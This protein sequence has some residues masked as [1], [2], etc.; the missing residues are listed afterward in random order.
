MKTKLSIL[1]AIAAFPLIAA[2]PSNAIPG[3]GTQMPAGEG[4]QVPNATYTGAIVGGGTVDFDVSPDGTRVT[5]F[6]AA[7]VP[8]RHVLGTCTSTWVATGSILIINNAFEA[9]GIETITTFEFSGMFPAPQQARGTVEVNDLGCHTDTLPWTAS[10]TTSMPAPQSITFPALSDTRLSAGPITLAASASSGLPVSYTSSTPAVC[11]IA[12]TQATLAAVGSCSITAR[13]PGNQDYRAATPV[14]R[15]FMVTPKPMVRVTAKA[16]A[17][18]DKLFIDVNP[19]LTRG[20][21]WEFKVQAMK[22]NGK[23]RTLSE[24]YTT[25]GKKQT[26]TLDFDRGTYRAQVKSGHGCVGAT[27]RTV[28]LR[29]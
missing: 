14:T 3:Q 4:Q 7:D 25:H 27:S 24:T 26:N 6:R 22:S 19:N 17:G 16:T 11:G 9:T 21:H 12:G 13:Q 10:T 29:R 15:S 8:G 2:T 23:W 18:K 28:R 20:E 5:R 1:V